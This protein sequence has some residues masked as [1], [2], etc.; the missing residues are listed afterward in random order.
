ME[1]YEPREDSFLL[2]EAVK[3]HCKGKEYVLDMGTGSGILALEAAK[4]AKEVL[5]AD[6]NKKVIENLKN[7]INKNKIRNIEVVHSDLFKNIKKSNKNRFD[8]IIF[9][10]PYL[11]QDRGIKDK[12]IYGGKKGYEL[13]QRFFDNVNDYLKDKGIILMV[14]SSITNKNK[15]DEIIN[16]SCFEFKEL[17][18]KHIFFETLY[19]YLVNKSELLMELNKKNIKNIKKLTKGHRG[20]IYLGTLNNKKLAIKLERKDTKAK[21]RIKNEAKWLRILN[22]NNIGPKLIYSKN[23]YLIYNFIEG[24]F[25]LDNFAKNNRNNILKIIRNIFNQLYIMDKLKINKEEMHHPLKHIIIT[26][27]N[28]PVLIDFERCHKT[29]KPKNVT[30]FCQFMISNHVV[31][32]LKNKKIKINK[33]EII[34]N[35]KIYKKDINKSNLNKILM[36]FLNIQDIPFQQGFSS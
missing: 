10:P 30:Q 6:I 31:D 34:K 12:T 14:F 25:V 35:A 21:N 15:V 19:V 27:N 20:I 13:I 33:N 3:R 29:N 1:V 17:K 23:N 28:K 32:I 24:E 22:K 26:K 36:R 16:N 4:K 2:L 11:P 18:Q 8:V 7:K 9:N 5:A